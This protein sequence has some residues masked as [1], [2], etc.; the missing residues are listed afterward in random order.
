MPPT[1]S[2]T[3]HSC[4]WCPLTARTRWENKAQPSYLKEEEEASGEGL[5]SPKEGGANM[6]GKSEETGRRF[7]RRSQGQAHLSARLLTQL[8]L[9]GL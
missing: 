6:R 4:K 2:Q 1:Q 5:S 9:S 3:G 8:Y 7:L